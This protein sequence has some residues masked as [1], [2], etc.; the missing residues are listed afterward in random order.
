MEFWGRT[1]CGL[2]RVVAVGVVCLGG[3]SLLWLGDSPAVGV[4]T[5]WDGYSWGRVTGA[6]PREV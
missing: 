5:S 1:P 2:V 6:E 4:R 3:G